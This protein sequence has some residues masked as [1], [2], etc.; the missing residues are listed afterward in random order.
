MRNFRVSERLLHRALLLA[1]VMASACGSAT[2]PNASGSVNYLWSAP[3]C[4]AGDFPIKL[5]IDGATV[6][7][8]TF[9][10]RSYTVPAY[11][12]TFHVSPGLHQISAQWGTGYVFPVLSDRKSTRLN[13]SHANISYAV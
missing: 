9:R 7:V 2:D 6:A 12:P 4:G 13:S 8:D 3:L 5:L 11:S 1:T 10:I